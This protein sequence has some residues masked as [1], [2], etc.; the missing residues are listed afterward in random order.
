[1]AV[2]FGGS[3]VNDKTPPATSL[4]VQTALNG[5]PIA[6][7]HGQQRIAGNLIWYGGFKSVTSANG[8]G[9]KG[10]IV[11]GGGKGQA[12]TTYSA[13]LIVGLCE[14]PIEN[15]T[16]VWS[17]QTIETVAA[18]GMGGAPG[19]QGATPTG[20]M[21]AQFPQYALGYSNLAYA[22]AAPLQ[23]GSSPD[24]PNL[25]FE[26]IGSVADALQETYTIASASGYAF[27]PSYFNL[28]A[29]VTEQVTVPTVS[30]YQ[31][32]AQNPTAS[33]L[34]LLSAGGYI[35]GPSIPGSASQGVI[36]MNGR[37]F[38]RVGTAPATGQYIIAANASGWIYTFA[39]ADAGLQVT[40]IDLAVSPGVYVVGGG[41]MSQVIGAPGAG[42]FSIS[43]Q[44]GSFGQYR[45]NAIDIGQ[46]AVII[47][48]MDAD[49]A[50]SLSD[51]LTNPRYG[52]G[53]P[54]ANIGD[55]SALHN[56]AYA[57]GMFVSPAIVA[58]Q[59]AN[60]YLN[61]F[62]TGLN[63]EFVWSDGLLTFVPYGDTALSGFGCAYTP[64]S[65]P[66]YALT[67]DDFLKNEGTASV[68][69]SAFTGDDPVVCVRTRPSDAY[70]DV[71]VEYLDRGNSYNPAI[72][73]AQDDAAVNAYGLRPADT[74][75]L[76]F[77]CSAAPATMSAQ[78][79][80]SRQQARNLYSFTVPW[81]FILLDPM[82]IVAINDSYLGLVD[83]WVR[84]REITENQ[85]DG[86]LT[87]TAEEYLQGTGSAPLYG[88]Q[89]R[90]GYVPNRATPAASVN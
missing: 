85:Q 31:I 53:F 36:D 13:D 57:N 62:A 10:G 84:V 88:S 80:L 56:Y 35:L 22:I 75:Q 73:E 19:L 6:I 33:T 12:Q 52:C 79:Q 55:L 30:P 76:H 50:A 21:S 23:L 59:A 90:A 67:D 8:G 83:Q 4:R 20:F 65:A 72:A 43:V 24:V 41:W 77:F 49:P 40:L 64:P 9:G 32:Q 86:T 54:T 63:G 42:E 28:S 29:C 60:D 34:P 46:E 47:D 66:I 38:A 87:I 89:T 15:I 1:M 3:R 82:D 27:T 39:A 58:S 5:Q 81:Y 18:I 14:G 16:T 69:V 44:P 68:G 78:L 71:K 37:V 51:Y 45:F 11:G 7:V 26:V 74:K 70:N 61:D 25:N 48:V 2:L 17:G